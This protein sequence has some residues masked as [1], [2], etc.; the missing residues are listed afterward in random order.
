MK[1]ETTQKGFFKAKL[2]DF[3]HLQSDDNMSVFQWCESTVYSVFNTEPEQ[4]RG[5]IRGRTGSERSLLLPNVQW[6]CIN[7]LIIP[8]VEREPAAGQKT[9]IIFYSTSQPGASVTS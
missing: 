6:H 1:A 3:L 7:T 4:T 8:C 9:A 2:G 5:A